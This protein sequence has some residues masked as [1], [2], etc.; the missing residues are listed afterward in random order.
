[1]LDKSQDESGRVVKE[2][3]DEQRSGLQNAVAQWPSGRKVN[4]RF[5]S[6]TQE[7]TLDIVSPDGVLEISLK[8]TE[9]GPTLVAPQGKLGLITTCLD[10]QSDQINFDVESDV[11]WKVGGQ[12]QVSSQATVINSDHDVEINGRLIKLNC[13]PQTVE[14]EQANE[15]KPEIQKS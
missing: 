7:D 6:S 8:F 4:L 1:M 13:D 14:P 2:L 5:S 9:S 10:I 11:S 3:L 15:L 12:F